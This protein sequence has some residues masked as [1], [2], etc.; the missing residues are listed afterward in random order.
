MCKMLPFVQTT[1]VVSQTLTLT[2]IAVERHRG[3]VRPLRT[4]RQYTRRRAFTMLGEGARSPPPWAGDERVSG[5]DWKGR[6]LCSPLPSARLPRS[7]LLSWQT[8]FSALSLSLLSTN[9]G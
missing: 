8:C 5:C 2:C 6:V 1:A 9:A 3:L 7:E 4:R